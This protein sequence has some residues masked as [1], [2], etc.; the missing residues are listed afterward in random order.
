M[1]RAYV[2]FTPD[3]DLWWLKI[4]KP[5]FRHCFALMNDGRYWISI[6]PMSPHMDITIHTVP[7]D[8]D[9]P[10]WL[11]AQGHHVVSALYNR[12]SRKPAPWALFTCVEVVKRILG[13]RSMRVITPYQLFKFIH[14]QNLKQKR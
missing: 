3:A 8:Y 7:A 14:K 2:V 9:L 11:E 5:G 1:I 6:D 12:S 13:I 4:L 10:A